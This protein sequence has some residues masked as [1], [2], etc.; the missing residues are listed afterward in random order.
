MTISQ[1]SHFLKP[2]FFEF[3][4]DLAFFCFEKSFGAVNSHIKVINTGSLKK[5]KKKGFK[6]RTDIDGKYL[7][8]PPGGR[9]QYRS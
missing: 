5:R 3:P 9:L 8:R 1:I 6:Y 2:L 7:D 4:S